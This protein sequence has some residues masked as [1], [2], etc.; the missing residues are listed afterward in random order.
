MRAPFALGHIPTDGRVVVQHSSEERI[1]TDRMLNAT[2][3]RR[4]PESPHEAIEQ[5]FLAIMF[6]KKRQW[7]LPLS[8]S[9]ARPPGLKVY[10]FSHV[11]GRHRLQLV[12]VYWLLGI[13][14]CVLQPVC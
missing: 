6:E 13:L 2:S 8:Q 5:L 9:Y 1:R 3:L 7:L 10:L 12:D 14:C 11:F 4:I